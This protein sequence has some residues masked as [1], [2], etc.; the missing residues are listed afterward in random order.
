MITAYLQNCASMHPTIKCPADYKVYHNHCKQD[1]TALNNMLLH[2][3]VAKRIM[4]FTTFVGSNI[5]AAPHVQHCAGNQDN[6]Q[7]GCRADK[8]V[9][10]NHPK[11][12][13]KASRQVIN[14]TT[15]IIS[16]S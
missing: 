16:M 15:T 7:I 14:S 9:Y 4:R 13:S 5:G 1:R 10:H 3:H 6:P 12:E 8:I 2:T 11:Q